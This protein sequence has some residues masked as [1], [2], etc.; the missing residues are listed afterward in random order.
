VS[1]PRIVMVST[2]RPPVPRR[3]RR[4]PARLLALIVLA[5]AAAA[6]GLA[7]VELYFGSD[8]RLPRIERAGDYRPRALTTIESD[9][10]EWI[11]EIAGERR[12]VRDRF[13]EAVRAETVKQI[14][15][16]FHSRG[17]LGQLDFVRALW[18][19]FRGERER[20]SLRLALARSL[21]ADL[22]DQGDV[23]FIKEWLL[24]LRLSRRLSRDETLTM[25]L[26]QITT[27]P[28]PP[29]DSPAP[30]YAAEVSRELR[31]RFDADA[32][33][34]LGKTV[35][36]ACDLTL[37]AR[38]REL[39]KKQHLDVVVQEA[40]THAVL[41]I[42]GDGQAHPL[43]G[44]RALLVTA[45]AL[46][47]QKWTAATP[48]H[49][50]RLRQIA[51]RSPL[52]AADALLDDGLPAALVR[53]LGI[54]AGLGGS[55]T[56]MASGQ[57]RVTPLELSSL[58]AT[59]ASGGLRRQPRLIVKV[60][61]DEESEGRRAALAALTPEVAWLTATLLPKSGRA[62]T[63]TV[64]DGEKGSW[65]GAFTPER[66]VVVH[67]DGPMRLGHELLAAALH[68]VSPRLPP[69]PAGLVARGGDWF[70]PGSL[71]H[72]DVLPPE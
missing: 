72:E 60:G 39:V 8:P 29:P 53:A 71:P 20:P 66:A 51:A 65:F 11:G 56:A 40:G 10:G 17:K 38:L 68:G 63:L 57:A 28:P 12:I 15:P 16:S 34:R 7:G 67:S 37:T 58:L 41:A 54:D 59:F 18:R 13:P 47:S 55:G 19:H 36:T 25:Y 61:G 62:A 3:G 27:A 23:R 4:W 44:M 31:E 5:A 69:R 6:A 32:L 24:A 42:I 26:N 21:L 48:L 35:T 2:Y 43:G 30:E 49:G 22:P 64:S 52:A 46:Q 14:D 50:E 1:D 45:A 33:A 70:L 9:S